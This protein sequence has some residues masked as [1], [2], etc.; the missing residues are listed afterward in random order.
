MTAET[1]I[2]IHD[3]GLHAPGNGNEHNVTEQPELPTGTPLETDETEDQTL[4][5]DVTA[6]TSSVTD[7]TKKQTLKKIPD[8]ICKNSEEFPENSPVPE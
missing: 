3:D 1:G 7:E 4:V 2:V 5:K 8:E 6:E